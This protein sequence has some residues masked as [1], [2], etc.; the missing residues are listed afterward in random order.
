MRQGRI[1]IA[2]LALV[3][4]ALGMGALP[5]TNRDSSGRPPASPA[6]PIA[7]TVATGW[8]PLLAIAAEQAESLVAMG[9]ARER[10]LLRIRAEQSA[11]HEALAAADAWLADHPGDAADPA[12][13]AYQEGAGKIRQAMEEAQSGFL[14]L[15]FERVAGATALMREGAAD[16]H[17][18]LGL[19][20]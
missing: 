8:R 5:A 1:V 2:L 12:V 15:D 13:V 7:R 10:N 11:M 20:P 16:L 3:G 4:I 17:R 6:A 14:R 19:L 9:E 18:A